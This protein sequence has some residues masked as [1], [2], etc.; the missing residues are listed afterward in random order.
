MISALSLP[1]PVFTYSLT[2]TM[3]LSIVSLSLGAAQV[4]VTLSL[5]GSLVEDAL[6][7]S[8]T[9]KRRDDRQSEDSSQ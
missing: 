3:Y 5:L 9:V 1:G 8:G 7:I 4:M 6:I 2:C